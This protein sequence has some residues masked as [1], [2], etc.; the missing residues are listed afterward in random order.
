MRIMRFY[1]LQGVRDD[2]E[3]TLLSGVF[4]N[5]QWTDRSPISRAAPPCS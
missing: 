2:C 4:S 1:T 3:A 5:C